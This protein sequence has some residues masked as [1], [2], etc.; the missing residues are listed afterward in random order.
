MTRFAVFFIGSVLILPAV[1]D[2]FLTAQSFPKT[3]EDV[4]FTERIEILRE[5][6][7]PY[8]VVYDE[9]G[10]CV[11]GCAYKGITLKDD[12]DSVDEATEEI[13]RLIESES[14]ND[15]INVLE[16][17]H[18]N[19]ENIVNPSLKKDWCNNGLSTELPLRFPVNMAGFKYL[20]SSDFGFRTSSP[21]GARFHPALDIG[22]PSGTPVYATAD[23]QVV[24]VSRETSPGGAGLYVSILHKN[25]LITQY[26]H[27]SNANVKKGD[28]VKACQLIATSGNSGMSKQGT[29]YA[30]HLDYRIRFNSDK[31]KYVDILCPC[32]KADR[33]TNQSSAANL[34]VSCV[35]SL[36]NAAYKFK[37]Y[38]SN[39]DDVK[40]SLWRVKNGHCMKQNT[41]LLPDERK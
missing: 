35:H 5:G 40:R 6:Y 38:N 3:F 21:N 32:K 14:K 41:D 22:C 16:P 10:F 24:A 37:P 23:G 11:S 1:A 39:T 33:K 7:A 25:G 9:N 27:L 8:E 20:I 29:A 17:D 19:S 28:K 30:P 34:D 18:G 31:N 26:L 12:M 4:S 36:F 15:T 13:A 2:S